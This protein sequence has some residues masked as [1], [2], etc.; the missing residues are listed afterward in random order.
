MYFAKVIDKI[1][2]RA[3]SWNGNRVGVFRSEGESEEQIGEYTRNYPTLFNTF[4][5][6]RKNEVDYA[7]YSPDYTVTRIMELPSCKDIGGEEPNSYGFCPV[8]FYVPSYIEREW[9]KGNRIGDRFVVKE[10]G[11][12]NLV[13]SAYSKPVS[14]VLYYPFG[15][16]AGCIWGDDSSWKIQYLGLEMVEKGT[17]I[18]DERF[19]Y[20]KLPYK[21]TLRDSIE[22]VDYNYDNSKDNGHSVIISLQQRFD[23]RTGKVLEEII[24]N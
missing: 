14:P 22:L 8:D 16:V 17:V 9:I 1:E 15:F 12:E 11:E 6:F 3:G 24:C 5:P 20:I 21:L 10:P 13:A 23:I 4:C 2:Y 19:G 7:L 18:R